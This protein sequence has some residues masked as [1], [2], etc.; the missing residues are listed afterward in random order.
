LIVEEGAR[1]YVCGDG[2]EMAKDVQVTIAELLGERLGGGVDRG[3]T[4]LEGMKKEKRF[5]LDIWS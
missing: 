4:Y 5:L 1:V 2:N 3:Q